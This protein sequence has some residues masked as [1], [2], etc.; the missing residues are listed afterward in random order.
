[1]IDVGLLSFSI[2]YHT[3]QVCCNNTMLGNPV[4]TTYIVE[5]S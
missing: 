2:P 4:G 5:L 1:M 3:G